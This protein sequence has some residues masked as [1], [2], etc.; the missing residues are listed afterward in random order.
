L[1]SL[2]SF[3]PRTFPSRFSIGERRHGPRNHLLLRITPMCCK[4]SPKLS[5]YRKSSRPQ[6]LFVLRHALHLSAIAASQ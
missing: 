2:R 1:N 5:G 3:I 4:R 6:I